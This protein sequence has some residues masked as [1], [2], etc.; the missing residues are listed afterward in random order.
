MDGETGVI[1]LDLTDMRPS[2]RA[3]ATRRARSSS[4][5]VSAPTCLVVFGYALQFDVI[6][7]AT[8]RDHHVAAVE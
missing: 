6:G 3:I 8:F 1:G 2:C 7:S 4:D 5:P